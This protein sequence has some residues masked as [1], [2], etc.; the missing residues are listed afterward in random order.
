[1]ISI[2]ERPPQ[3]TKAGQQASRALSQL[4][5]H[6]R[7]FQYAPGQFSDG[8]RN[9]AEKI[10][11]WVERLLLPRLSTIEAKI[12]RVDGKVDA[13]EKVVNAR[14]QSV[15]TQIDAKFRSVETQISELKER[16]NIAQEL[17]VVKAQV[18]DLRDKLGSTSS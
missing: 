9:L 7:L 10:P 1:M 11:G 14:F 16:F 6:G 18:K 5:A 12:D 15:E 4:A 3:L 17:A 8:T 13:L 2:R